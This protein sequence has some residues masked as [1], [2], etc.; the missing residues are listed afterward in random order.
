MDSPRVSPLLAAEIPGVRL[1]RR[2]RRQGRRRHEG[3]S[4]TT[5]MI[6]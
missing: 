1:K 4:S 6:R 2:E 3:S 5:G